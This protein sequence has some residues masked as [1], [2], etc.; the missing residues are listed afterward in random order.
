MPRVTEALAKQVEVDGY[1]LRALQRIQEQYRIESIEKAKRKRGKKG[2]S[3]ME[4]VV[5]NRMLARGRHSVTEILQSEE[6]NRQV[7]VIDP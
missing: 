5:I 3:E 6:R 7:S 2:F 1:S 4:Q